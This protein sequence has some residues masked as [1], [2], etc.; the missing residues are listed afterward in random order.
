MK[1]KYYVY[2][3]AESNE[4][5]FYWLPEHLKEQGLPHIYYLGEL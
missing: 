1:Q 4:L 2:Y 5:I 3:C